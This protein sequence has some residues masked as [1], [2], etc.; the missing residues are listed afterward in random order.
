MGAMGAI[1]HAARVKL[2]RS[3]AIKF[4]EVSFTAEQTELVGR[5]EREARAMS[6]LGHPHCVSVI[7]FGV[8]KTPYIVMEYV[9]GTSLDKLIAKGRTEP[10]RAI[11]IVRQVL[12]GLAHAHGQG[13]VHRDIKPANIMLTEATGTGDHARILDFGLAKLLDSASQDISTVNV[14]L[15]TPSYMSPEQSRGESVDERSDI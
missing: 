2:G 5:F 3:V 4:L 9:T 1:Y 8:S 14:V 6:R 12:A 7:D 13:I 10:G 15:G 11:R